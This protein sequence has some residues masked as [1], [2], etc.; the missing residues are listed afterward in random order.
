[1]CICKE[2]SRRYPLKTIADSVYDNAFLVNPPAQA[3]ILL[4]T[5]V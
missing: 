5:Y 2:R 3:E 4:H 1:M